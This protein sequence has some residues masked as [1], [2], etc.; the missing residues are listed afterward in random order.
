MAAQQQFNPQALRPYVRQLNSQTDTQTGDAT[1]ALAV[2]VR[3]AAYAQEFLNAQ[4]QQLQAQVAAIAAERD[5]ANQQVA[6]LQAQLDTALTIT[7][8]PYEVVGE[9]QQALNGTAINFAA[10]IMIMH[11][12]AIANGTAVATAEEGP[13]GTAFR[14]MLGALNNVVQAMVNEAFTLWSAG[15]ST[16]PL[17]TFIDE[18]RG[19]RVKAL[20]AFATTL[21]LIVG[22]FVGVRVQKLD[23]TFVDLLESQG[24]L[25]QALA[26]LVQ[27]LT[28]QMVSG[29]KLHQ[30]TD[31]F[32]DASDLQASFVQTIQEMMQ[33]VPLVLQQALQAAGL[34]MT[35][36]VSGKGGGAAGGAADGGGGQ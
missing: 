31:D 27:H 30:V 18:S 10:A 12:D 16:G 25:A 11:S 33:Q 6:A 26:A 4:S 9:L 14:E 29:L 23:G 3:Q 5:A 24:A 1:K 34:E 15:T 21:Q 20:N 36:L 19:L 13:S 2:Q 8:S 28:S 7:D 32:W 22:T 17:A 35:Q